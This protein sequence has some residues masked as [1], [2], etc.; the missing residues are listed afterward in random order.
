[1]QLLIRLFC[2]TAALCLATAQAATVY[3]YQDEQGRW[4]FSDKQPKQAHETLEVVQAAPKHL[5]PELRFQQEGEQRRLMALN[6]LYAPVQFEVFHQGER[7]EHWVVEPRSEAPVLAGG[8]PLLWLP[9]YEYRIRLGRPINRSDG[10][11]LRPPV[12]ASSK[13]MI[14][15][16][17]NGSFSHAQ[18]PN[19]HSVD[20]NMPVGET[21]HAAR[22]GIVITV[23]DDYHMGGS[24]RFF[25]DKANRV[26]VLHSDDT[27]A[28]YAHILLGSALV[29]E[30]QRV[31]AGAPLAGAGSS[32]YSTG[33]H[34]HFGLLANDGERLISLP[35]KFKQGQRIFEPQAK[36]WLRAE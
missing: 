17:F 8:E 32:G 21:V 34:L 6:P 35:F 23:K 33:P 15:Q 22:E 12:P 30:G 14:T 4:H 11:P 19:K 31:K 10:Q 36:Q 27:L 25:L 20:I 13:F 1:M 26:E 18:E 29:K 5:Q 28:V 24:H 16:G 3:R 2:A 7:V 9:T